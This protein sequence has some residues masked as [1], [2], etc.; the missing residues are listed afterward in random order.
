MYKPEERAW[1]RPTDPLLAELRA[2]GLTDSL[3]TVTDITLEMVL[4]MLEEEVS[5]CGLQ[6][7]VYE[8]FSY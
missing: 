7:L 6:L 4:R 1:L 3:A 5:V 8:A 2:R